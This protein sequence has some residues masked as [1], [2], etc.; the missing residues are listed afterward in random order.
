[1]KRK[2]LTLLTLVVATLSLS[3]VRVNAAPP[4]PD[5]LNTRSSSPESFSTNVKIITNIRPN[6]E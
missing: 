5:P 4:I 2:A 1:M 6:N 3:N